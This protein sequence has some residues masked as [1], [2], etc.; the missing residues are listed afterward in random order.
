MLSLKSDE[1]RRSPR[2]PLERLAKI[3]PKDSGPQRY[4]QVIDGSDGGVRL[5]VYGFDVPSE[6]LLTFSGDGLS[7][8]G[9]YKVIWRDGSEVGAK[10]VKPATHDA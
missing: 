10:F 2:Y 1:Q 4:C 3:Q 9:T 5:H 6:F 8:D 7:K